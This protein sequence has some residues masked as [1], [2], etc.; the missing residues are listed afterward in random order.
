VRV[1]SIRHR[2]DEFFRLG[3]ARRTLYRVEGSTA[4]GIQQGGV[5]LLVPQGIIFKYSPIPSRSSCWWVKGTV[6]GTTTVYIGNYYEWTGSTSTSKK[7]YYAGTV[8]IAMRTGTT[9][10]NW[11]FGDHLGSTSIT[12]DSSGNKIAELRYKTWG[13]TRYTY[14]TT[15]T[16]FKFTGQR[17]ES[18]ITDGSASQELYLMG[19][20]YYDPA[21]GRFIQADSIVPEVYNPLAYDRYQYVYSNPL[22][23]KDSSGH[24][25]ETALDLAFIAYDLIQ[26]N[27]GGWTQVN[28]IA[29]VADVACAILPVATGGGP[30]VRAAMAGGDAALTYARAA[31]QV[32]EA[33]RI[34]QGVEK[35]L[36][37]AI[38]NGGNEPTSSGN[39]ASSNINFDQKKLQHEFDNHGSDFGIEGNWNKETGNSF[40][41]AILDHVNGKDT[42]AIQGTYRGTITGTNYF[43][44]KTNLWAFIDDKGNFV[45]GWK[46]SRDQ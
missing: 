2:C 4:I 38:T 29:L 12:T 28:T 30:A 39:E 15:P 16:T 32:P 19:S 37:F 34:G 1:V 26:I 24:W 8:R 41:Q 5:E 10:L 7:F 43:N 14:G 40:K 36:Q 27:R 25:A 6:T 13:E 17:Q 45:A 9:T 31:V 22:R 11:L 33:I 20:R 23:Y 21:L 35:G 46:L 44:P 42:Q 3:D 18:Y